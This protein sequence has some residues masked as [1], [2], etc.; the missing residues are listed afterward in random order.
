MKKIIRAAAIAGLGTFHTLPL[1]IPV[2]AQTGETWADLRF[3]RAAGAPVIARERYTI[4]RAW[5]FCRIRQSDLDAGKECAQLGQREPMG[6]IELFEPEKLPF[7]NGLLDQIG[8]DGPA[9]QQ[10]LSILESGALT[11]QDL[12]AAI[13]DKQLV[14]NTNSDWATF[15]QVR[16]NED[17]LYYVAFYDNYEGANDVAVDGAL[18]PYPGVT[19]PEPRGYTPPKTGPL[20]AADFYLA[21]GE[22]A[23]CAQ[24]ALLDAGFDPKG[25]DGAPGNGARAALEGWSQ[26]NGVPLPTFTRDT[27]PQICH[28]LT[29]KPAYPD[30]D[31]HLME[32]NVWPIWSSSVFYN[33]NNADFSLATDGAALLQT[34]AMNFR[35]GLR[36]GDQNNAD[37]ALPWA[38]SGVV[39]LDGSDGRDGIGGGNQPTAM[40]Q[41]MLRL[42]DQ[43]LPDTGIGSL[44]QMSQ[45][46][47]V[48]YDGIRRALGAT[49]GVGDLPPSPEWEIA[50][51]KVD[52]IGNRDVMAADMM[53]H[54][55]QKDRRLVLF[56][57]F[58]AN[59]NDDQLLYAAVP[60]LQSSPAK[61]QSGGFP[62]IPPDT[63]ISGLF[64]ADCDPGTPP[65]RSNS[66]AEYD[67]F[68]GHPV[69]FCKDGNPV[70]DLMAWT[71]TNAE[72]TALS[73]VVTL[74]N[75]QQLQVQ[76]SGYDESSGT[77]VFDIG[78]INVNDV[79]IVCTVAK[80]GGGIS[81]NGEAFCN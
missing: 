60:V 5:L 72:G 43:P 14:W 62:E 32:T 66:V 57:A 52:R 70:L 36:Y 41:D 80:P 44:Q 42:L 40:A 49:A 61:S 79:P 81:V 18:I 54:T 45:T 65:A 53:I 37:M 56:M 33:D 21:D 15:L 78:G 74:L 2:Q 16:V 75:G 73:M 67:G 58:D 1:A 20:T 6:N 8:P 13:A 69:R 26:A 71:K 55:S 10:T 24:Q 63:H 30:A 7:F 68:S 25:V 35:G 29:A 4:S 9:R 64:N 48:W 51:T 31:R 46:Y 76:G 47:G 59:G 28:A 17:F 50:W 12:D 39:I 23:K 38:P 22:Y 27:A 19:M 34:S 77:N 3:L 11:G